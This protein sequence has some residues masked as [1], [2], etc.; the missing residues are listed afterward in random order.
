MASTQRLLPLPKD[1]A[2]SIL[3]LHYLSLFILQAMF[4]TLL[5][6]RGEV[7]ITPILTRLAAEEAILITFIEEQFAIRV[8]IID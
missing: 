7:W 5:A 8:D 1:E 6:Y 2:A 3:C 4:P